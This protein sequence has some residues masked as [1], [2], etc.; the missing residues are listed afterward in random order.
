MIKNTLNFYSKF[1]LSVKDINLMERADRYY[2][3]K[4][5]FVDSRSTQQEKQEFLNSFKNN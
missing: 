2:K 1:E 3:E 5:Q 4:Q